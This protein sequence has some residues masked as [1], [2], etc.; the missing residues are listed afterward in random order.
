M[1]SFHSFAL[2]FHQAT[3]ADI[4]PPMSPFKWFPLPLSKTQ[5][6]PSWRGEPGICLIGKERG[7]AIK[8]L[9]PLKQSLSSSQAIEHWWAKGKAHTNPNP[10]RGPVFRVDTNLGR[11][12][13][14]MNCTL[15]SDP[16]CSAQ[17]REWA[18]QVEN[19]STTGTFTAACS[20]HQ[21]EKHKS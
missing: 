4:L 18:L 16:S 10:V 3:S 21:A 2:L 6:Y 8:H 1:L 5:V 9:L 15:C 12:S 14:N 7:E 17:V 11:K 19:Y 20:N 13:R